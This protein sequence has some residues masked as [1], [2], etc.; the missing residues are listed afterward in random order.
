VLDA[1]LGTSNSRALLAGAVLADTACFGTLALLVAIPTS[2]LPQDASL[3]LLMSFAITVPVLSLIVGGL[4]LA[5]ESQTIDSNERAR[6]AI[7][8]GTV[9]HFAIQLS[10]LLAPIFGCRCGPS[11]AIS[12]V[13]DNLLVA[14]PL[15]VF[16]TLLLKATFYLRQRA[17][18][19]VR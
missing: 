6:R 7:L 15:T 2:K 5:M 17:S 16:L 11:S 1:F 3:V 14:V 12:Y 4:I 9:L 18:R 13:R 8:A 19:A 10:V